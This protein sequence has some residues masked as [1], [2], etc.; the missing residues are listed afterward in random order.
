MADQVIVAR[1]REDQI[2]PAIDLL[3]RLLN[4]EPF[5]PSFGSDPVQR[6]KT[7]RDG[8]SPLIEYCHAH[9]HPHVATIGGDIAGLALWMPP[10]GV[11]ASED[12]E[13]EYGLDRMP[14]IFGDTVIRLRPLG[15][16]LRDLHIRA[17]EGIA[18]WFLAMMVVDPARTRAGIG[19]ALLRPVLPRADEGGLPCYADTIVPD[20]AR[21]Y[22]RYGFEVLV[23]GVEPSTGIRFWTMRRPPRP[24]KGSV[25]Q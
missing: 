24:A 8:F 20:L 25:H 14:A 13:R 6:M 19:S 9:A 11:R 23:E 15:D 21:F 2:A 16:M 18:H 7:F 3:A 4:R 17:M 22:L 12:E 1:M 10:H 5:A